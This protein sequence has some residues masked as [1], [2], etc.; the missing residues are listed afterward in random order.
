MVGEHDTNRRNVLQAGACALPFLVTG[1]S[2]S[3]TENRASL[4]DKETH[5]QL[6]DDLNQ[7]KDVWRMNAERQLN[8]W[9]KEL[10]SNALNAVDPAPGLADLLPGPA[11]EIKTLSEQMALTGDVMGDTNWMQARTRYRRE[12]IER[13]GY[14]NDLQKRYYT[15]LGYG[16]NNPL[17]ADSDKSPPHPYLAIYMSPIRGIREAYAGDLAY[18]TLQIR[19]STVNTLLDIELLS[20]LPEDNDY[21]K[22]LYANLEAL[23]KLGTAVENLA[24][25]HI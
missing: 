11:S 7:L 1:K 25:K 10:Q 17:V 5:E 2:V 9:S 20:H 6:H 23:A 3:A 24:E 12:W 14:N 21:Q 8:E 15:E 4:D 19:G 16:V 22:A 18:E 13:D